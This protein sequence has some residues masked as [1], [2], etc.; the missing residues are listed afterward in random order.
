MSI[1]TAAEED[2]LVQ[3]GVHTANSHGELGLGTQRILPI[4]E[5]PGQ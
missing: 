1:Q 3:M 5:T 4:T 2:D